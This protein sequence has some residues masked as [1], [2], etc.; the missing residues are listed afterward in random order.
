MQRLDPC[1][2]AGIVCY[3]EG[4]A[5]VMVETSNIGGAKAMR[6]LGEELHTEVEPAQ[7]RHLCYKQQSWCVCVK[8]LAF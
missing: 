1:K 3:C 7:G 2:E 5:W 8:P 6:Y 4:E